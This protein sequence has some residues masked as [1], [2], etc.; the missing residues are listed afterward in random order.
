MSDELNNHPTSGFWFSF[1]HHS[2]ERLE[3]SADLQRWWEQIQLLSDGVHDI[4]GYFN[5]DYAG[6]AAGTALKFKTLIG[7]P[8]EIPKQPNQ[9]ALF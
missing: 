9:A 3:R 8:V 4:F 5:N 7:Q 6:F 2:S 1:H